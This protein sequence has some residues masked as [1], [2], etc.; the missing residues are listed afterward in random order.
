[1]RSNSTASHTNTCQVRHRATCRTD[2]KKY[3]G[4][5]ILTA[6]DSVIE[7]YRSSNRRNDKNKLYDGA[8]LML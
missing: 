6:R 1:M 5:E 2:E 8:N 7:G 3:T 4:N